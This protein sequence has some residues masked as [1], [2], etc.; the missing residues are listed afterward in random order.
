MIDLKETFHEVSL[1]RRMYF[2]RMIEE[3]ELNLME[4]E[5]LV[6]LSQHPESN[7]FTEIMNSKGYAKSYISKA[8]SN[9]VKSEYITKESTANN[10]K[11][12][13]LYLL[14]KSQDIVEAYF[15]CVTQFRSDAFQNVSD[16]ER[17]VF[18]NVINKILENLT[19]D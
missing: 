15:R 18:E 17:I 6:F 13:R 12:Y 8:I 1:K 3:T 5:I 7:T 16:E 11:V 9:L 4:I 10:K 19:E 14:E 2:D